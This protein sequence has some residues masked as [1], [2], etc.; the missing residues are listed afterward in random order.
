VRRHALSP[1]AKTWLKPAFS[2]QEYRFCDLAFAYQYMK[3]TMNSISFRIVVN[4][5]FDAFDCDLKTAST[6]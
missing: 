4:E 3:R 6:L 2:P 1:F 5:R